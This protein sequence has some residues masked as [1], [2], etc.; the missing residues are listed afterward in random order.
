MMTAD[1]NPGPFSVS[2]HAMMADS[3]AIG[4]EL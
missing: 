1:S 3:A 4:S 2:M